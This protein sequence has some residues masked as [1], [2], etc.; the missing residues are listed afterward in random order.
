MKF[1]VKLIDWHKEKVDNVMYRMGLSF[2]Q[3]NWLAF[4]KGIVIGYII[5]VYI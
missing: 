5:G 3:L 4:V 2:Y 1:T